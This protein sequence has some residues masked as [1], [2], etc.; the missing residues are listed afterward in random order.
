MAVIDLLAQAAVLP[1]TIFTRQ[2]AEDPSWWDRVTSVASGVLTLTF[3]ALAAALIL[4][5]AWLPV[6]GPARAADAV[7]LQAIN[8]VFTGR[9]DPEQVLGRIFS[10]FCIGK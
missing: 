8:Y 1:D 4:A 5:A 9:I 2:V 10:T 7:L 3:L 6:N